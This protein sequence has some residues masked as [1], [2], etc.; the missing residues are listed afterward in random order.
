MNGAEFFLT[1]LIER[2]PGDSSGSIYV[3]SRE[4]LHQDILH[5]L[6]NAS[7]DFVQSLLGHPGK[8]TRFR[9]APETEA[10]HDLFDLVVRSDTGD[11]TCLELKVD[12]LW[13]EDQCRRQI[14]YLRDRQYRTGLHTQGKL[15]V[16][17]SAA[18]VNTKDKVAE[19]VRQ[20]AIESGADTH[21]A[22]M[23]KLSH[24]E[25]DLALSSVR[26]EEGLSEFAAAYRTAL[27]QQANRLREV[28]RDPDL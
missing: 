5:V 9:A 3:L 22:W 11:E 12:G 18:H 27:T 1:R 25:L 16:F 8:C 6:F 23:T 4:H 2:L 24:A 26:G 28:K 17:N 10:R 20:A 15:I 14:D 13:G 19:M 7:P 21:R